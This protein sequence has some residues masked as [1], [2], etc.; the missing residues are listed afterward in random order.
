MKGLITLEALLMLRARFETMSPSEKLWA[1][2]HA[3]ID[4]LLAVF[5]GFAIYVGFTEDPNIFVIVVPFL[6]FV[7]WKRIQQTKERWALR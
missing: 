3:Q 4:L 5:L 6:C 2:F 7:L 1:S